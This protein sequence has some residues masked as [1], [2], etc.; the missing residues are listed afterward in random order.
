MRVS[1]PHISA[2]VALAPRPP[3][4]ALGADAHRQASF[5]LGLDLDLVLR[6]L[7]LE[8]ACA[9]A[10][11][12]SRFRNQVAA[13][14]MGAWSRGWLC[15]VQALHAVQSGNYVA[16]LPLVQAA[17]ASLAAV[18]ES[19]ETGAESWTAWLDA[20]AVALAPADH[21]TEFA[22]HAAPAR[23][24]AG[25][26]ATLQ[27][28]IA[29]FAEPRFPATLLLAGGE[30]TP[31]RVAMTFGDR[32]FHLALA[33]LVLGWLAQLSAMHLQAVLDHPGA[34]GMPDEAAARAIIAETATL[35]SAPGR[36]HVEVVERDGG[37]R[38]LVHNWRRQPGGAPRRILL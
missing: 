32:D 16:A 26:V 25:P 22:P 33:E 13:S 24:T 21:A 2:D 37:P 1:P 31:E 20:G 12:V 28:T 29:T 27:Q 11:R 6:G 36:C 35:A 19:F 15:R 34:F 23:E 17:A 18:I 30:S 3:I 5:V 7:A 10:S 38:R 14:A 9:E 8:G 4:G